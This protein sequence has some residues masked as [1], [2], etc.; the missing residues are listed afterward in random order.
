MK[1]NLEPGSYS[2]MIHEHQVVTKRPDGSLDVATLNLEPSLTEQQWADDCDVNNIM[3]RYQTTGEFRHLTGKQGYYADFSN[4]TDYRDMLDTVRYAQ[5]AFASLPA[6]L[7][8]R[9]LNDPGKLLEF[10]QDE[11]NYD[12]GVKL[13]LLEPR[14]IANMP[15]DLNNNDLNDDKTS[16]AK[17]AKKMAP[18][19]SQAKLDDSQES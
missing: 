3:K 13:G 14:K 18:K 12:E 2:Q 15:S 10:L 19:G 1:K 4:I 6:D 5:E 8:Q 11:K 9:F 16:V 7:R 17:T